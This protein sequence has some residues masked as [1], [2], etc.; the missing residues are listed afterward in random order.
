MVFAHKRKDTISYV[1]FFLLFLALSGAVSQYRRV[2]CVSCRQ[3]Y[4]LAIKYPFF[5]FYIPPDFPSC[6][7]LYGISLFD[8]WW[9][10]WGTG[11]QSRSEE[12]VYTAVYRRRNLWSKKNTKREEYRREEEQRREKRKENTGP[13]AR[14]AEGDGFS[15]LLPVAS[16][17]RV[18]S[19]WPSWCKELHSR[20]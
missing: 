6:V 15:P 2:R 10:C 20:Y 16:W 8:S 13:K 18:L 14:R 1:F 3:T 12:A 17:S 19:W 7:R 5:L 4:P 11:T 9:I